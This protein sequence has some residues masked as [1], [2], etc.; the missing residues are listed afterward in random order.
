MR[1][2]YSNK[3]RK[4][5]VKIKVGRFRETG[6]N[7]LVT[8]LNN[9]A[10]DM[11]TLGQQIDYFIHDE[12]A[13][14]LEPI[15]E[16]SQSLVPVFTGAL[17]STAFIKH[18][19]ESGKTYIEIG[20]ADEEDDIRGEYFALGGT[21]RGVDFDMVRDPRTYAAAVHGESIFNAPA[22]NVVPFLG[23]ALEL[24]EP[25]LEEYIH[26]FLIDFVGVK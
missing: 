7:K 21:Y 18:R 15:L 13:Y 23:I 5:R 26:N 16:E 2:R 14:A 20:Y 1:F 12:I 17:K 24:G 19:G 6:I 4:T 9:S 3:N 8:F 10:N 11:I 25:Q 22:V